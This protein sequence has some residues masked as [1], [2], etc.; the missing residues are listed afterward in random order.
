M[1]SPWVKALA[2]K[3]FAEAAAAPSVWTRTFDRSTPSRD[4]IDRRVAPSMA[5]PGDPRPCCAI[6]NVS[7]GDAAGV[8]MDFIRTAAGALEGLTGRA[9]V[10]DE[11]ATWSA[12]RS[13][14][15]SKASPG[16]STIGFGW[17][18]AGA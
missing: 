7:A 12:T 4:S 18:V 17:T 9:P 11:P 16:R 5:W 10:P 1:C 14:S 13:A 8:P 15:R 6:G 3:A 2:D